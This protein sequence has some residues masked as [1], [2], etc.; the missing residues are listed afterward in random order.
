[1]S[2]GKPSAENSVRKRRTV[3]RGRLPGLS[4]SHA[5]KPRISHLAGSFA[6]RSGVV[7]RQDVEA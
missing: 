5:R 6:P 4:V 7:S 2:A 3:R 1:M